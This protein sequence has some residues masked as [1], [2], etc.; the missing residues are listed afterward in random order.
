MTQARLARRESLKAYKREAVLAAARRV[1]ARAGLDG[2]T[3]RA[4]AQEAGIASGT[5]YLHFP[6]KESIYAELLS[7][8]LADLHRMMRAATRDAE[9]PATE[10]LLAGALAFYGFYRAR[11]EDLDLGLYLVHGF[12]PVSDRPGSLTP[13]LDRLLNGRLIQCLAPLGEAIGRL[14]GPDA[15][16]IRRESVD[17]ATL[18]MG[19]LLLE[20]SG[21]MKMLG[22]TGEAVL[23]RQV[24][25]VVARLALRTG[26][27]ARR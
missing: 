25:H 22:D 1:F 3:I 8:S 11:P 18:I 5:V 9:M 17:M 14:I 24:G 27:Q 26:L 6:D 10:A 7:A 2:A 19:C 20:A 23:R 16:A 4:I 13:E 15:E 21:R 12:K